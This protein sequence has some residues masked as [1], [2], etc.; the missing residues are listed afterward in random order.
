MGVVGFDHKDSKEVFSEIANVVDIYRGISYEKLLSGGIQWPCETLDDG[1]TQY[2]YAQEDSSNFALNQMIMVEPP[3]HED[4]DFPYLLAMGRVLRDS[5][6]EM[7]VDKVNKYNVI[8]RDEI[9]EINREDATELGISDGQLVDIVS[10]S[11]K[12]RGIASLTSSQ[13]GVISTTALFGQLAIKLSHSKDPDPMSKVHG[14]PLI[15]V[16]IE[17]VIELVTEPVG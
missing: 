11:E 6:R 2:L 15:P 8:K 14:L 13:P 4:K 1:G 3:S 10:Y 16:R 17:K 12:L 5:G 7:S 9:V